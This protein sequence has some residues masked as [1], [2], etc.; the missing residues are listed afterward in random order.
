MKRTIT[1]FVLAAAPSAIG[2]VAAGFVSFAS[3]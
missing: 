2:L 1:V 3:S